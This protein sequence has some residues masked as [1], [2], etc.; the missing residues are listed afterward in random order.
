MGPVQAIIG[1][2]FLAV[3]VVG[4]VLYATRGT[5][6]ISEIRWR[7]VCIGVVLWTLGLLV[8][9]FGI[10]G[11]RLTPA[12]M[13]VLI[14]EVVLNPDTAGKLLTSREGGALAG[15][16]IVG[17]LSGAIAV[18]DSPASRPAQVRDG[19]L[20]GGVTALLTLL[21]V[22]FQVAT[23]TPQYWQI[24]LF[25]GFLLPFLMGSVSG[26]GGLAITALSTR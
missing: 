10:S 7:F 8:G 19:F 3:F 1:G 12:G 26:L 5:T 25:S 23:T 6:G 11:V 20:V 22:I 15:F 18:Q 9:Y 24:V 13:F 14:L 17:L 4:G 21:V 16:T 2:L